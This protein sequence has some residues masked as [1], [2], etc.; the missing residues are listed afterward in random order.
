[1]FESGLLV[2][3]WYKYLT[4]V[5]TVLMSH[6]NLH[7]STKMAVDGHDVCLLFSLLKVSHPSSPCPK[8]NTDWFDGSEQEDWELIYMRLCLPRCL[9][10]STLIVSHNLAILLPTKSEGLRGMKLP[11]TGKSERDQI[12]SREVFWAPE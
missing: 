8:A 12:M 9:P 3:A 7:G 11:R 6:H 1:M 5:H 10:K 4:T 2:P